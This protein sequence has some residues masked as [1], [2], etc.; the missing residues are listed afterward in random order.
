MGNIKPELL[1]ES[2]EGKKKNYKIRVTTFIKG[3][4]KN[5]FMDD[6]IK[7]S[8][9]ESHMAAHIIDVYYFLQDNIHNFE[10]IDPNKIKAYIIGKIKL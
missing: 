7:Y 1:I 2:L 6:C 3:T 8:K 10:K 4:N 9:M 5:K